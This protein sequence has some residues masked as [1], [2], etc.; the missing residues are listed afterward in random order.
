MEFRSPNFDCRPVGADIDTLV[1]HHT[2]MIDA[3]SAM[4]RLCNPEFKVSCHYLISKS[5]CVIP[6]VEEKYRAWHAGLSCWRGRS[7]VNDFSLGVELDNAGNEIFPE[8]QINALIALCKEI[9]ARHRIVNVVSHAEIAP[10]RKDDP[11]YLFPWDILATNKIGIFPPNISSTDSLNLIWRYGDKDH[12]IATLQEKLVKYGFCLNITGE[13]DLLTK[14]VVTAFNRRF[15][16]QAF[17]QGNAECWSVAADN[18][19]EFLLKRD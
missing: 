4:Q 13:F 14:Q 19:L 3:D 8:E 12:E 18:A 16:P 9:F 1:L 11:N 10:T 2:N 7:A 5:G 6:L 17:I 15:N